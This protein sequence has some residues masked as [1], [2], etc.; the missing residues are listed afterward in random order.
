MCF[1]V[2]CIVFFC[3]CCLFFYDTATTEIYTYSHTLSLH[4]ALPI[5]HEQIVRNPTDRPRWQ[6]DHIVG[7]FALGIVETIVVDV[8]LDRARLQ[9]MTAAALFEA[10]TGDRDAAVDT[11]VDAVR[12]AQTAV[13]AAEARAGRPVYGQRRLRH[14][15]GE[16][17]LLSAPVH[18][19]DRSAVAAF[20]P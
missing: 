17:A 8:D 3:S 13:A 10:R 16:A 5:L 14:V 7:R 6:V 2:F 4:D 20:N 18:L 1:N 15:G 11:G 19:V 12:A 9:I